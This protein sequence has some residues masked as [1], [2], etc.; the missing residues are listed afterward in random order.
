MDRGKSQV[1]VRQ[2][3]GIDAVAFSP[4]TGKLLALSS[5]GELKSFNVA[6][7]RRE[8]VKRVTSNVAV[9]SVQDGSGVKLGSVNVPVAQAVVL[10]RPEL[11]SF[12]RSVGVQLQERSAGQAVTVTV[13]AT[14]VA[15]LI[16]RSAPASFGITELEK[17]PGST[18]RQE[19]VFSVPEA[20]A[21]AFSSWV[22]DWEKVTAEN[23]STMPEISAGFAVARQEQPVF[24]LGETSG[25]PTR[26]S[27]Q[28]VESVAV[29]VVRQIKQGPADAAREIRL[30]P[31]EAAFVKAVVPDAWGVVSSSESGQATVLRV[32]KT[33]VQNMEKLM[34]RVSTVA[35]INK[36]DFAIPETS[37]T[38]LTDAG[39][40]FE[41]AKPGTL[42]V[43]IDMK[44]ANL[45]GIETNELEALKLV[46]KEAGLEPVALR[47]EK[48]TFDTASGKLKIQIGGANI[49][50]L[51]KA[52]KLGGIDLNQSNLDMHI[53][54]DGAGVPL[55]ISQQNL[56]DLQMDGLVP[57]ILDIQPGSD[58]P[59]FNQAQSAN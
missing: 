34:S 59:L 31:V 2:P 19:I 36:P 55:P 42:S 21:G 32:P 50:S 18:G 10:E 16:M 12:V 46:A 54:R 35:A 4:T 44:K 23:P 58:M 27:P 6:T 51:D 52:D 39:V 22:S 53:K 57:V 38:R 28:K 7:E 13:P 49:A 56:E 3:E 9:L 43:Q 20:R 40:T 15:P 37:L 29:E 26:L 25:S 17:A 45:P 24:E 14:G 47:V 30:E 11:Q 8:T 5:R 33:S 1:E 48:K 41:P